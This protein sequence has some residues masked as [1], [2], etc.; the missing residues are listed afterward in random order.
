MAQAIDRRV[1]ASPAQ[2]AALLE[3]VKSL[4]N[5]ADRVTAFYGCLY[6]AGMRPSEAAYL[7][8]ND[9]TP[10]GRCRAGTVA[11]SWPTYSRLGP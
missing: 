9:C 7:R 2:V 10:P 1:V 3:A 11:S 5:R 4:G 8:Q 6:Y